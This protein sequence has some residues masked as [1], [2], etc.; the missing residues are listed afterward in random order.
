MS[1]SPARRWI[2]FEDGDGSRWLFDATFLLSGW[3]CVYGTG[4]Q[5]IVEDPIIGAQ[6]G[7]CSYGAHLIDADDRQVV[8]EAAARLR[9]D[10]WQNKKLIATEDDLFDTTEDGDEVTISVD[11]ACVFLNGSD[12]PTGA[13]C[14]LHFACTE[15]GESPVDW[16]PAVCWQ[17]PLR[18]EEL[19]D[20]NDRSTFLLR[21][22]DTQD[23][24]PEGENFGWWCTADADAFG[25]IEPVYTR[26]RAE[27]VALVGP[28]IYDR[29]VAE[30]SALAKTEPTLLANDVPVRLFRRDKT[31][32]TRPAGSS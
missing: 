24:G 22:W 29:L 17:L 14:A 18:L 1:E 2:S 15:V 11:G 4:C 20:D 31:A 26:L 7:C 6:Q 13:G 9:T 27:L 5:G 30:V 25:S 10:Q 3:H 12:W 16:K 23:W 32:S 21:P 19:Q 28:V 8:A